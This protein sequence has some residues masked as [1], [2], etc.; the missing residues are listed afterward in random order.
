MTLLDIDN[1]L[2]KLIEAFDA[3]VKRLSQAKTQ[4][5]GMQ[6]TT[7]KIS[8]CNKAISLATK[9]LG[10]YIVQFMLLKNAI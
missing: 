10:S 4:S 9:V 1:N 5:G 6:A 8:S 7:N 3:F 2:S